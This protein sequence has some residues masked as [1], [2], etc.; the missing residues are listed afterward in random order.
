MVKEFTGK[1][2]EEAL[3]AAAKELGVAESELD[4]RVI[5]EAAGGFLGLGKK[6]AVIEVTLKS[7]A[8]EAKAPEAVKA[9]A[10]TKAAGAAEIKA[11]EAETAKTAETEKDSEDR[12]ELAEV[13]PETVEEVK[14]YLREVISKLGVEDIIIEEEESEKGLKLQLSCPTEGKGTIIGKRGETLDALQY[15][16][17]IV[18]NRKTEGYARVS[19][20]SNG[21]RE[22]REKTLRQL[23]LKI[24]K[25][26]ARTGRSN[27]LEPMNPY[28]RRIIHSVISEFEG[29]SSHSVGE[30]PRRKVVV[31]SD[32]P[33]KG[34][35]RRGGKGRGDRNRRRYVDDKDYVPKP[36]NM[37][38]LKTSFEKDYARP[39]PEDEINGGLYGKIE[40]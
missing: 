33:K 14:A 31:T 5:Q 18:V 10:E 34:G 9:E 27:S 7:E 19:L 2:L 32:N 22:K 37:D 35:N 23:A 16:A 30:E 4:Y 38:S 11:A 17:S 40:F 21:Y 39:K 24:A 13:A 15:L 6:D 20:D 26:V 12:E 1:T 28:E 36:Q 25:Q 8:A 29:V 3:E